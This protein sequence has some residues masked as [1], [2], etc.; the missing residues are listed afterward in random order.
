MRWNEGRRSENVEDRRG[1][2]VS[3]GVM[4]GGIGTII[5]VLIALYFGV[6]PSMLLNQ[7]TSQE[8]N[9]PAGSVSPDRP[10]EENRMAD[11]VSV[12]LADTEDTWHEMFRRSGKTYQ[13]P[14][15]VLFTDAV[16]S[17]CGFAQSAMGPFYCPQDNKVYIDLQF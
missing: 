3:R 12:V 7:E 14:K 10:P 5:I 6:D 11:F 17:A 2:R 15:L 8:V 16:D 13:A 1:I 4:G 9:V